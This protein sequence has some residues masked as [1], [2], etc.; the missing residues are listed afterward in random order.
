MCFEYGGQVLPGIILNLFVLWIWRPGI[1][2][3]YQVLSSIFMC[4]EKITRDYYIL[5]MNIKYKKL[6]GIILNLFVFWTW[7]PF[8]SK[9]V[10]MKLMEPCLRKVF[11]QKIKEGVKV[12]DFTITNWYFLTILINIFLHRWRSTQ[13]KFFISNGMKSPVKTDDFLLKVKMRREINTKSLIFLQWS[14]QM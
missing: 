3:Y 7:W 8:I 13:R 4:F 9:T 10:F 1:T 2:R 14:F 5:Y 6:P 12:V 11:M